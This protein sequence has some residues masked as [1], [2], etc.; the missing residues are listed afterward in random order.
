[1]GAFNTI[2]E[3][4][5]GP[6]GAIF[7]ENYGATIRG[8][9]YQVRQYAEAVNL[10]DSFYSSMRCERIGN[11]AGYPT[12]GKAILACLE[13]AGTADKAARHF[14]ERGPGQLARC[15]VCRGSPMIPIKIL[16][17]V[18]VLCAA[19][20]VGWS[21]SG[22]CEPWGDDYQNAESGRVHLPAL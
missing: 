9:G 6:D 19:I 11:P 5:R 21:A 3:F 1:M 20:V 15:S 2:W 18:V 7:R 22:Q 8:D 4:T 13:H 17:V 16:L 12:Y 14:V 10:G